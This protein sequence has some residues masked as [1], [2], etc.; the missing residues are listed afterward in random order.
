M[1]MLYELTVP[2]GRTAVEPEQGGQPYAASGR[3]WPSQRS[4]YNRNRDPHKGSMARQNLRGLKPIRAIAPARYALI[5]QSGK[6][7]GTPRRCSSAWSGNVTS[8]GGT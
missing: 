5:S 6:C 4:G 8:V 7:P 3:Q 2:V 1:V